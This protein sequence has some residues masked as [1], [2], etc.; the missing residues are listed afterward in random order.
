MVLDPETQCWLWQGKLS[1]DGYGR[2]SNGRA[3]RKA[4]ELTN[5]RAVPPGMCVLHDCDVRHCVNPSHLHLGTNQDNINDKCSR[6]R[7]RRGE[8]DPMAKLTAT[9]V[10]RI[11]QHYAKGVRGRGYKALAKEYNLDPSTIRSL[12]LGETWRH[13][14]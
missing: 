4:W 5:G 13:A 11:R 2:Y 12:L 1:W 3:H 8:Q 14:R 10:R 7:Q 6:G 9:D